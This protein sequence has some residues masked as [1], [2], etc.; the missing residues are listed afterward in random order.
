MINESILAPK[1]I[2]EIYKIVWPN[3]DNGQQAQF[4]GL[5]RSW[6]AGRRN[7]SDL[8]KDLT[9][10]CT[11]N[12]AQEDIEYAKDLLVDIANRRVLTEDFIT[13][14]KFHWSKGSLLVQKNRRYYTEFRGREHPL[15]ASLTEE[16]ETAA[17]FLNDAQRRLRETEKGNKSLY[18]PEIDRAKSNLRLIEGLLIDFSEEAIVGLLEVSQNYSRILP[19]RVGSLVKRYGQHFGLNPDRIK[20][21]DQFFEYVGPYIAEKARK[22]KTYAPLTK[23]W[24]LYDIPASKLPDPIKNRLR[25]WSQYQ[26]HLMLSDGEIIPKPPLPDIFRR[27]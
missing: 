5:T 3:L 20:N 14:P 21:M 2:G 23:Y 17:N 22:D 4:R 12:T 26:F 7:L 27:F 13:N 8:G 16:K 10:A 25:T 11:N 18:L 24:T 1:T 15:L 9:D 6:G 19:S